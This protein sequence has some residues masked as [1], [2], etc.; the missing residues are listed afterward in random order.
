MT[1]NLWGCKGYGL[2]TS[3]PMVEYIY[4]KED[5][6]Y[7]TNIDFIICRII[8]HHRL[9]HLCSQTIISI[10]YKFAAADW[11][12]RVDNYIIRKLKQHYFT[13]DILVISGS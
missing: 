6:F 10:Y 2:E 12:I 3:H 11:V 7:Q 9:S 4:G 8:N 13:S 5:L 1:V